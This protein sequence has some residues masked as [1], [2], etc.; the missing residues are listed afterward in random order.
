M[1][2]TCVGCDIEKGYNK[3]HSA[4]RQKPQPTCKV[5]IKEGI[6]PWSSTTISD[7]IGVDTFEMICVIGQGAYGRVIQVRHRIS[8]E[9][10]AMVI[11]PF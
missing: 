8:R 5:C 3:F 4:E 1:P 9:I 10:F 11:N 2:L 6:Q 7:E